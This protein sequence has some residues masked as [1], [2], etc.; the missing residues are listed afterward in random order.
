MPNFK[1]MKNRK[2]TYS[3]SLALVLI[4]VVSLFVQG[5]N[6]GIDFTGG[7]I[8]EIRFDE[9]MSIDDLR[10]FMEDSELQ[11]NIQEAGTNQF[12]VRTEEVSEEKGV[13]LLEDIEK[14]FGSME[15][16]RNENVSAV[17]GDEL[18]RNAL[19]A[20]GIAAV[21]MVAYIT[22]RFEFFFGIS[23]VL[24]LLHD[25]MIIVGVFSVFQIEVNSAFVAA[26]L[27]T[28]GYS[29]NDSIVI[30][31]RIRENL[32][33]RIKGGNSVI[34]DLSVN[35]SVVRS[36]STTAVLVLVL[37]SL[38]ILGGETIQ[39]FVLAM[40]IGSLA[41]VYSSIFICSPLWAD[42]VAFK[43]KQR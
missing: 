25:V 23:A 18:T 32:S 16:N 12:I 1:F 38:I 4:G 5:L 22:F 19:L 10:G 20:L 9:E 15:I 29:I 35:Q 8:L 24:G 36:L 3:L 30:F 26:L 34:V 28:V 27:T 41:G 2:K 39:D 11:Y 6:Y 21:L 42:M 14:N 40:L 43:K 31:D 37:L 33:K 13:Q 17:V 7:S